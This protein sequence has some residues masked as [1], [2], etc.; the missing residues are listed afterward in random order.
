V[1]R[2]G[3]AFLTGL[4]G[5]AEFTGC[6]SMLFTAIAFHRREVRR[7]AHLHRTRF[8]KVRH[9]PAVQRQKQRKQ[10]DEKSTHVVTNRK[11]Q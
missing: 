8:D 2:A 4:A 3:L 11:M 1:Q 5:T 10:N 7:F 6:F 9:S